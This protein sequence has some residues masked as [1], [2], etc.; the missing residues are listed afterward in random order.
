MSKV[1]LST[2]TSGYNLSGIN[3]NFQKL[4]DE[5]N[6][7]VLYRDSP[8]GE[9]NHM[10]VN[11]DMNGHSILNANA[12]H[13]NVIEIGGVPIIPGDSVIDPYNGTREALRRSYA[14]AS[15]TL[16]AGSFEVG[17]FLGTATDVLLHEASGKAYSGTGPFPQ[18]VAAGTIPGAGFTDRSDVLLRTNL[19]TLIQVD[20]FILIAPRV[21]DGLHAARDYIASIGGGVGILSAKTYLLEDEYIPKDRVILRGQG[22]GPSFGGATTLKWAGG[23]GTLKAVVRSSQYPLGTEG[24]NAFSGVGVQN[25]VIDAE[26]CDV[27]LYSYY[28]TNNSDFDGIVTRNATVANT[29]II[30]SW[31]TNYGKQQARDGKN[32]G[33]VIGKALFGETGDI[34][35]NSCGWGWMQLKSNGTAVASYDPAGLTDAGAGLVLG[36][37]TNSNHFPS[38][39]SE[40]NNGVGIHSAVSFTNSFGSIYLESNSS[41]SSG[42]KC[43][44]TNISGGSVT[45]VHAQ[46][47]H[48]ATNQTLKNNVNRG[49]I[50]EAIHRGD[51]INTFTG[52]AEIVLSGGNLTSFSATDWT[53]TARFYSQLL[54][55][56][57][58][59]VRFS[60][61]VQTGTRFIT[62]SVLSYPQV[63]VVPRATVTLASALSLGIDANVKQNYGTV[64][65]VNV[66]VTLRHSAVLTT[67]MH[68]IEIGGTLPT[69]D[70]FFDIYLTVPLLAGSGLQSPVL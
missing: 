70:T 11:L 51:D 52:T 2:I 63:T 28:S 22:N 6:N 9:P 57:N 53:K 56:Q 64:F 41:A 36:T 60:S 26:G 40:G 42:E 24:V 33:I 68:N 69:S 34:A 13:A 46:S 23:V 39:Q 66:P 4:E 47:V 65:T 50:I 16:V 18:S 17:G 30:K 59:N 55:S 54:S 3:S 10:D 44:W 27:G 35:V 48:L 7:K 43:A 12:I 49:L 21:I 45:A 20:P 37:F 62:H 15:L 1:E 38:V 58:V 8:P 31:F 25:C 5:L 29:Y 19:S 61:S 14:D 67:G 32:R